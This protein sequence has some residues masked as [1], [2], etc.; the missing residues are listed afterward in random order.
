MNK[1]KDN[2]NK[3]LPTIGSWLQ[4]PSVPVAEIM[5][6]AGYDWVAID[7]E[8]GSFSLDII[9]SLC[10]ALQHGKTLPLARVAQN[11]NKDIRQALDAGVKG[12]ILPMIKNEE[13]LRQAISSATYPPIGTRGV[14]YSSAN[15]YGKEF[16]S[17]VV[18]SIEDLIII[19]QIEHIDAVQSL[20]EILNVDKLDG[21]IIGPYD[22]S[23]SMNLTAQFDHRDFVNVLEIIK[24]KAQKK[25]MPLGIHIVQ[26]DLKLL[27]EKIQEGYHS[28]KGSKKA[29]YYAVF[30]YCLSCYRE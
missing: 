24:E 17:K 15:L 7:L 3:G 10:L 21:I 8:H 6:Q 27:S 18:E 1:I 29:L 12:I 19:A 13:E 25:G 23:A 14:G 9:P 11:N 22:L 20:D 5:G 26:P 4:I 16:N 30:W 28:K 2:L